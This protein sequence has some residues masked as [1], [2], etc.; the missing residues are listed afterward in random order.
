[1]IVD[2]NRY[3]I[4]VNRK[5]CE[6]LGYAKEELIGQ[7]AEIIHIS[8][9]TF[10]EFGEKAFNQVRNKKPINLDWPFRKKNREKIWFRIAGDPV[11]DK[12]S[13]INIYNQKVSKTAPDGKKFSAVL[14]AVAH[15][16]FLKITDNEW[17]DLIFEG[18]FIFDLCNTISRSLN[19]LRI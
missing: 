16:D 8:N 14:L 9:K 5:F 12:E 2:K 7:N 18:G 11:A 19:P 1:M 4:E 10:N 3:L 15:E 17:K 13:A 6:M